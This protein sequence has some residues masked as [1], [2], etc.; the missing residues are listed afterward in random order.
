MLRKI[1][2]YG[3]SLSTAARMERSRLRRHAGMS[4]EWQGKY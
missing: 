2:F 3:Y 4:E 1:V